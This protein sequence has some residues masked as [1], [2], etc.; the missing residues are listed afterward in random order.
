MKQNGDNRRENSFGGFQYR[1]NYDEYQKSL[2]RKRKKNAAQGMRAFCLTTVFVVLLCFASLMVVMTAALLRGAVRGMSADARPSYTA[3]TGDLTIPRE[4][5]G[6]ELITTAL[7]EI[8]AETTAP[9]PAESSAVSTEPIPT[10]KDALDAAEPPKA[11]ETEA[12]TA[13][14][15]IVYA[16]A[17]DVMSAMTVNEIA[18][19]CTASTVTVHCKDDK[20]SAVG[21]GFFL[22]DDGYLVTNYHVIR[23]FSVYSAYLSDGSTVPAEYI[24]SAPDSDI[25]LL[26]IDV[27]NAPAVRIGSSSALSIGDE[28]IAIGTPGAL[29]FAGT[30]THG[31][32]SGLDRAVPITDEADTVLSHMKM[33]QISAVINPGNSGG[34]LFNAFGEVIGINTMKYAGEGFEGMGFSIPIDA[35]IEQ[36]NTWVND[37]RKATAPETAVTEAS[38]SEAFVDDTQTTPPPAEPELPPVLREPVPLGIVCEAVTEDEAALYRVPRGVLIRFIASDSYAEESGFESGD[39]LISAQ[40]GDTVTVFDSYDVYTA[41]ESALYSGDVI[42]CT[43][44]RAGQTRTVTLTLSDTLPA[45]AAA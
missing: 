22:T 9:M 4:T 18:A 43:V 19:A 33:I 16:A 27:Q 30:V 15:D 41:W 25:A 6:S 29:E 17:P 13:P 3:P 31:N 5:D 12:E 26:K 24:A 14:T 42:T 39:I 7:T 1:W 10:E 32:V 28:V 21:S 23:A 2:Q 37:H 34:P 38:D 11:A 44:F 35:V 40:I 8:S 45:D 20:Q 36:L